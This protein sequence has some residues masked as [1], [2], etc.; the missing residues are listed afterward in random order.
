MRVIREL[1][2]WHF[3]GYL[4]MSGY[5]LQTVK[6]WFSPRNELDLI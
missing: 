4:L 1:G 2:F 6:A 5:P 3:V